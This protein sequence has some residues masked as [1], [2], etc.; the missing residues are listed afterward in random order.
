MDMTMPR[1]IRAMEGMEKMAMAM[2]VFWV[3]LPR[4]ATT[5]MARSSP[6][7][8]KRISMIR[9]TRE[10]TQPPKYPAATPMSTPMAQPVMTPE[11]L[12]VRETRAP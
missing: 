1:T 3:P 6:G 11:K 9:E 2:A 4:M 7:K 12:R 10:S 5:V 8:A